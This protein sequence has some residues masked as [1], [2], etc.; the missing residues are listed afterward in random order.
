[1]EKTLKT[2]EA[3]Q[4]IAAC[5][6]LYLLPLDIA[7]WLW[8]ILFFLPDI[9][10]LGYLVNPRVGAL[11]YNFCH[12]KLLAVA[13]AIWGVVSGSVELQ[14]AGLLMYAHA[15]FD[16]MFGFGLKY[17]DSFKNTHLGKLP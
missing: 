7:W 5:G 15:A 3:A 8:I 16:R 9:G 2:E 4:M 12:Y 1:M 11:A 10:I 17:P 6:M 13:L 14:A